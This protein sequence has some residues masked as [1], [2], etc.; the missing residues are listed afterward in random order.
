MIIYA[1]LYA[2]RNVISHSLAH[3]QSLLPEFDASEDVYASRQFPIVTADVPDTIDPICLSIL[4]WILILNCLCCK[5]HAEGTIHFLLT[6]S[7]AI[8]PPQ[9]CLLLLLFFFLSPFSSL[10]LPLHLLLSIFLIAITI[11]LSIFSSLSP[12]L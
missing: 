3:M 5:N 2:L 1:F 8:Y 9:L 4:D 12:S 11:F 10:H 7:L 6:Q